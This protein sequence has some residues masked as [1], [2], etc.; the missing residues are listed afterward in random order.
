MSSSDHAK[1]AITRR[2]RR[3]ALLVGAAS[4]LGLAGNLP[5]EAQDAPPGKA[6]EELFGAYQLTSRGIGVQGTYAIEGLLPGGSAIMDLTLPET[7][8][9]FSSGPSGYGLA[10]L[11]YPGGLVANFGSLMAQAGGP[12]DAVPPYPIKAEAFFPAGPTESDASQAG[13]TVQKVVTTDRGVDSSA[14]F[15][16]IDA[17]PV[18]SIGSLT[19]ASRGAIEGDLAISRSRVVLGNVRI[20]GGLITIDSLVTD[21]V[22]AHDGQTGSTAGGTTASGVKFLGL[23]ATLTGDGLIL[24]EA[25]PVEGPAAPLGGVLAPVVGPLSSITGPVQQQLRAVLAQAVPQVDDVLAQAGITLSILDPHDEQVESGAATR[26]T[27][28]LAIQMSYKGREQ[29]ALVDLINSIPPDLKPNIGPIPNPVT[30]LA[31]NHITGLALGPASVSSLATPPFPMLDFVVPD[32]PPVG[33]G[34][35]PGSAGTFSTPGFSTPAAQLPT[36][37]SDGSTT[38]P[39]TE[40]VSALVGGAMPALL[41]ALGLLASPF[42]G[43]GSARLA[44]LALAPTATTSCPIGL[45]E[46][47]APP[48][49]S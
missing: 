42:F 30:F 48:R 6:G 47:S 35:D 31:E 3:L 38:S 27:T 7:L 37:A 45:D 11:A 15:P 32:L 26:I 9:N 20:L 19:S 16:A 14:S 41:V 5:A 29:Q 21:L 1:T 33:A 43:A 10:S 25:P 28:G 8:A 46:P 39:S 36:P 18:V 24:K 40:P 13:G 22:A 34:F 23:D 44:D 4:L 17:P 12:A 49:P 2:R